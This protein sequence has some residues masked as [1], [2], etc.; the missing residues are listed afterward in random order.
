[1]ILFIVETASFDSQ[2]IVGK[3]NV[4]TSAAISTGGSDSVTGLTGSSNI[5][6]TFVAVKWHGF[7]N[8]W[9]NVYEWRDGINFNSAS[10]YVCL[11]PSEFADNTSTNYTG[12]S[13][14]KATSNGYISAIGLDSNTPWA[15]IP[16]AVSG[17]SSTYLCDEYYYSS[18][19]MV[20]SVGGSWSNG[21]YAGLFSLYS[22]G[23]SS[24][25]STSLGSRLLVLPQS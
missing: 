15:Q 20:A 16:T 14:S 22:D 13:Y 23:S 7:E 11:N 3:G 1:M 4:S 18:G 9:G 17:S 25:C 12:L 2:S 10:S 21:S 19:W 24:D 8:L 5:S 6:Y